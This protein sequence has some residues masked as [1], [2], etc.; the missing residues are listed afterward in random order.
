MSETAPTNLSVLVP[1]W[2]LAG[3]VIKILDYAAHGVD[4]GLAVTVW[5]PPL[6]E[7]DH[8]IHQLPVAR[9]LIDDPA[10]D[11]ALLDELDLRDRAGV[12]HVA[13]FTEPTHHRLIERA[14]DR[15][16][17]ATLCHLVQGTRHANPLWQDGV[18]YRLLHR[19][20]TRIAVTPQVFDAISPLVN[21]R[22]SLTTIVEGHAAEYFSGRPSRDTLETQTARPLRVL[23][24]TWKSDLGDRVAELLANDERFAFIAVRSE[25]SW[26][27][28]RNRYHGADV[29]LCAPGPE[30]GFY[31]PGLEAMAAEVAVVSAVVGGNATY[32]HD[33]EN[34]LVVGYDDAEQ[35]RAALVRLAENPSLRQTLVATGRET[36]ARHSL[37]RERADFKSVL[38][39]TQRSEPAQNGQLAYE[40]N[41]QEAP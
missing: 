24:T 35:H 23:Y 12:G 11:I 19:P 4:L 6:P 40:A 39:N 10:V 29:L 20:M 34:A 33:G 27:A 41:D 17:G 5:A 36:I 22:F 7:A 15:P 32:L 9:R 8:P 2:G 30:E 25:T 37:V 31:L 16:L 28:L 13:L 38:A 18:N 1:F 14:I 26:P 21:Q 3:G